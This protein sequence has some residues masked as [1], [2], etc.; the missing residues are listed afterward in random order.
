[1][2]CFFYRTSIRQDYADISIATLTP[3]STIHRHGLSS[4]VN[5]PVIQNTK[6][7]TIF[8][9]TGKS[10]HDDVEKHKNSSRLY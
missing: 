6:I 2:E 9:S 8:F 4:S 1:M 3:I 5:V 7:L 10:V